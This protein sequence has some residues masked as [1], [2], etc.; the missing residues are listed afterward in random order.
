[1]GLYFRFLFDEDSMEYKYF[2][3]KIDVARGL[4]TEKIDGKFIHLGITFD[5]SFFG[6]V[7]CFLKIYKK[8]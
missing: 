8:S 4:K 7:F 5:D 1:M 3:F 6:V 2:M